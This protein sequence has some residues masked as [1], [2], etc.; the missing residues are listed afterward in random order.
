[1]STGPLF[2][3]GLPAT[4]GAGAVRPGNTPIEDL[5]A[6]VLTWPQTLALLKRL[7]PNPALAQGA[8]RSR[9]GA[10]MKC[11]APA[12]LA[13]VQISVSQRCEAMPRVR[14]RHWGFFF[15]RSR[16]HSLAALRAAP[17]HNPA[18]KVRDAK[19]K[20]KDRFPGVYTKFLGVGITSEEDFQ[21]DVINAVVRPAVDLLG[22]ECQPPVFY[23]RNKKK[24]TVAPVM[25]RKPLPNNILVFDHALLQ[26]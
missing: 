6:V 19:D 21:V 8:G 20:L 7:R 9:Q 14:T 18:A 13:R 25:F 22:N 16:L 11:V 1:M 17:L 10:L 24:C 5:T 12:L 4:T 3:T 2:D 26:K 15:S 23:A